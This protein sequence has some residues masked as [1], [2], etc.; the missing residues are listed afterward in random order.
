[1]TIIVKVIRMTVPCCGG[2]VNMVKESMLKSNIVIPYREIIID[3]DG[4]IVSDL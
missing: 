3:T 4:T 2:I 1:C